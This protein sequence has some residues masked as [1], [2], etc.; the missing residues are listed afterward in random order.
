MKFLIDF[1]PIALFFIA[2]KIWGIYVA[3]SVAIATSVIQVSY[4]WLRF[5]KIDMMQW[6]TLGL[7][8]VLGGA[9]LV[10][11]N[12][13]F[14][15]WK[16]T[17]INWVLAVLFWGSHY[18]GKDP[19]IKR[20]MSKQVQLPAGVWSRLNMSWVGFFFISGVANL[21]V[22]YHYSTSAWVNFKLFGVL[23]MTFIFVIFQAVY[24]SKYAKANV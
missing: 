9:T 12:V 4:E 11:H 5:R 3:T 6:V 24:L 8:V 17:V 10:L 21:Y 15:K 19:I 23:G 1:F 16:P 13:I 2:Y 22:V 18:I 7:I 20:M 14:I